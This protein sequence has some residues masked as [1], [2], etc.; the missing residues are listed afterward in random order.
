MPRRLV[1]VFHPPAVLIAVPMGV[2][3]GVIS[4]VSSDNLRNRTRAC[5]QAWLRTQIYLLIFA[6]ILPLAPVWLQQID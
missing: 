4:V 3:W 1:I 6:A 5:H 2:K